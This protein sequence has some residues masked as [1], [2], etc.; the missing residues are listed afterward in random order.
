MHSLDEEP[1]WHT[2]F[3]I[4]ILISSFSF[5]NPSSSSSFLRCTLCM[6]LAGHSWGAPVDGAAG[7]LLHH[8]KWT[9]GPFS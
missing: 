2:S 3:S 9:A 4:F 5:S 7:R 1:W 6:A 8:Q